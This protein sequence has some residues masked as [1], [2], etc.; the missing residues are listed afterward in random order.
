MG[1]IEMGKKSLS[2]KLRLA[3]AER[4]NKRLP[5]FV[6]L[7]SKR[8]FTQNASRR[9]WRTDKLRIKDES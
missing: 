7:R 4:Q 3:K 9:S 6:Y 5:P 1:A 8:R 2:K